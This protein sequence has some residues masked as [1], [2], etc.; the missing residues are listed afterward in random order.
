MKETGKF[1]QRAALAGAV[2]I[3][4]AAVGSV[5]LR[6]DSD[7]LATCPGC[8]GA[9]GLEARTPG[10]GGTRWCAACVDLA[11]DTHP[12]A[13][14]ATPFDCVEEDDGGL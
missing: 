10:E 2:A 6:D 13:A 9:S 14:F 7:E 11:I 12:A 4:I 3:P 1:L 8:S 5:V